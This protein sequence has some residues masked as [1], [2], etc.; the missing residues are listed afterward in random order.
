MCLLQLGVYGYDLDY[1]YMCYFVSYLFT[2]KTVIAFSEILFCCE[3]ICGAPTTLVV[4]G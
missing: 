3:I 2:A 1:C 4:K